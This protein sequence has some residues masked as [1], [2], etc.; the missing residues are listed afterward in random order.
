MNLSDIYL[1][2]YD[3]SMWGYVTLVLVES[4]CAVFLLL[5][6][7]WLPIGDWLMRRRTAQGAGVEVQAR[8][9]N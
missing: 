2:A 3:P 6:I 9:E 8:E 5:T 7:F 1:A 4:A